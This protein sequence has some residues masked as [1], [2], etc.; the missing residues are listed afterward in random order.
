[1]ESISY[2]H[3]ERIVQTL[4][5]VED[6]ILLLQ[7]WNKKV[8]CAD[9]YLLTPE[10]VKNLAASCMLVEAI[11][12]AYK[13]IDVLTDGKLLLLYPSIPWKAVKG[14]RDHIAHGYFEIDADV[15]YET[16]KHD[17]DPLLEATRFFLAE[18][19]K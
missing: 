11:G 9:D 4:R 16:I 5:Q 14:I 18:V 17:L 8:S 7:D 10:G 1:M 12:E 15:I 2:K 3:Q 6:S 19:M 13:K